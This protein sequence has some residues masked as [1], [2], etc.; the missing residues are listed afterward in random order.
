MFMCKQQYKKEPLLFGHSFLL[1]TTGS[2][3]IYLILFNSPVGQITQKIRMENIELALSSAPL[4]KRSKMLSTGDSGNKQRSDEEAAAAAL[5]GLNKA[6]ETCSSSLG[7]VSDEESVSSA[8]SIPKPVHKPPVNNT[9]VDHTYT[10]YSVVD[11]SLL[12]FLHTDEEN[13]HESEISKD[14]KKTKEKALKK[15]KKIFGDIS[16][17]RKNSGG[18]VKPFPEKVC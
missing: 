17:T 4:K 15:I 3:G 2:T 6:H 14:E 12:A 5:A 16:P 9:M 7:G 8:S 1:S 18:V 11:E 10:D 13:D